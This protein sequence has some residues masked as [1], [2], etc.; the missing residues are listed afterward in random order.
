MHTGAED[1][2]PREMKTYV[3]IKTYTEVA[4]GDLFIYY[5]QKLKTA[6]MSFN[7]SMV[8]HNVVYLSCG[9]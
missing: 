3:H 2:Y 1:A 4:I 6:Q 7:W 9:I 8:K 5:S